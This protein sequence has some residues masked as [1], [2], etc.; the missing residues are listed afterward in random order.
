M[1]LAGRVR[2]VVG[3]GGR[4][5]DGRGVD[6]KSTIPG[7]DGDPRR[8]GSI[9]VGSARYTRPMRHPINPK[10]DCV[11]KALL[12]SEDNRALL[13]HFLNAMLVDDLPAP[14]TEVEIINPYNERETF[15]DKLTIVDVKA[16][17]AARRL[18]QIEI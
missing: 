4:R 16:R 10:V 15:S 7:L 2:R 3:G 1:R 6:C 14:I 8:T 18:F 5:P 12:G 17:D 9:N 11:F 13:I